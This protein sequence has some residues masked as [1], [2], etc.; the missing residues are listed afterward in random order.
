LT[1]IDEF[2]E[3][4]NQLENPRDNAF[5]VITENI[6]KK[7]KLKQLHR[8]DR[9]QIVEIIKNLIVLYVYE[10]QWHN[11]QVK[12]SVI[13]FAEYPYYKIKTEYPETKKAM[14]IDEYEKVSIQAKLINDILE[15]FIGVD[16]KARGEIFGFLTSLDR[17]LQA[18][19]QMQNNK[20]IQ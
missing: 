20:V 1:V 15:L 17:T 14:S 8:L 7:D 13:K 10:I 16:G 18:Q 12:H 9:M 4:K 2:N 5:K 11:K 19:Q 3:A 6:W